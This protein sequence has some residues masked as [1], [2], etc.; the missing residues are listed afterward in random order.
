MRDAGRMKNEYH[1]CNMCT[2]SMSFFFIVK[3]SHIIRSW[4]NEHCHVTRMS[5]CVRSPHNSMHTYIFYAEVMLCH[6]Q[7]KQRRKISR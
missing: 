4:R 7:L 6:S 3:L 1:K 5:S 2:N